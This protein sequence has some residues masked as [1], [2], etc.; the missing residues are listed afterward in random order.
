MV[1]CPRCG[2]SMVYVLDHWDCGYWKCSIC[3]C[4]YEPQIYSSDRTED[5][6]KEDE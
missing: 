3:G 6:E 2:S 1:K 5:C 4:G